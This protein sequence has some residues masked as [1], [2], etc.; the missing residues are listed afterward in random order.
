ML[1]STIHISGRLGFNAEAIKFMNLEKRKY[2]R[3]AINEEESVSNGNIYLIDDEE[4]NG[5]A[6]VSKAGDYYY[7]NVGGLFD[8][9]DIDYK[10][11]SV[12]YDIKKEQ[13]NLKDMFVLKRRSPKLRAQKGEGDSRS[14]S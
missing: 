1:T 5:T 3:V 6:K 11:Y 12:I 8:K 14:E 4:F 9:L 7:L 10:K 13:Y 2:F